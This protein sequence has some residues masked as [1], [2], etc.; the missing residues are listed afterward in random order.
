MGGFQANLSLQLVFP[1]MLQSLR[2]VQIMSREGTFLLPLL[3]FPKRE[4]VCI[5]AFCKT[6]ASAMQFPDY[7]YKNHTMGAATGQVWWVKNNRGNGM[8]GFGERKKTYKQ[9]NG[10][11]VYLIFRSIHPDGR[12]HQVLLNSIE[13]IFSCF[14]SGSP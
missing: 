3:I 5:L 1:P 9:V 12:G 7:E 2:V 14:F 10:S 13:V 4:G 8:T 11:G 6:F